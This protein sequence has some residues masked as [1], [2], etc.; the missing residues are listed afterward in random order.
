[1]ATPRSKAYARLR[2]LLWLAELLLTLGLLAGAIASGW[3]IR[4]AAWV[5]TQVSAWPMRV[6][7]YGGLLWGAVTLLTFPFAWIRGFR[8]EHRFR[9]STRTFGDWLK[10]YLKEEAVGLVLG[11]LVLEGLALLLRR[12]P[13]HWWFWAAGLW[14]AWSVLLTRVA[15][16]W[17]IPL[18]YRQRPIEDS[19]L[20]QRLQQFLQRCAI[21]VHGIFEINLSRT[22]RKANACLCGMGA[23]RRVLISDTLLS[24]YPPEEIEVILAHEVGHHR[25]RHIALLILASSAT[26][27]LACWAVNRVLRMNLPPLGLQDPQDLAALPVIGLGLSV[28]GLLL[29]PLLN[30]LSRRL[31]AEADRFALE[32]TARP[33]AFVSA[34]RRLAEQNLAEVEPPRWVEWY[35]YDH[36]SIARRIAMAQRLPLAEAAPRAPAQRHG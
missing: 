33:A 22:T 8:I 17:L 18:F 24:N 11:A 20:K 23:S 14:I 28:A 27:G 3:T 19:V 4:L 21:P 36:P 1:M 26:T 2:R 5:E 34:M 16:Q 15:P 29:A 6:A 31:E 30:G 10:D 32:Q 12:S 35:F 25:K 13:G 9:L 7:L